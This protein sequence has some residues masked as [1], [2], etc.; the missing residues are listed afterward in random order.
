[1][2]PANA[3]IWGARARLACA[4][5]RVSR[6]FYAPDSPAKVR[7][8][9]PRGLEPSPRPAT[10]MQ[11]AHG[12]FAARSGTSPCVQ[13]PCFTANR[14][15]GFTPVGPAM[16]RRQRVRARSPNVRRYRHPCRLRRDLD[17]F[18]RNTPAPLRSGKY[19]GRARTREDGRF[20]WSCSIVWEEPFCQN[21][22]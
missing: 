15:S 9:S 8:A 22:P 14:P 6:V 20:A 11:V 3:G 17:N 19:R 13:R 16:A 5:L 4:R 2:I 12:Q 1:M 7:E 18:P 10:V 21:T